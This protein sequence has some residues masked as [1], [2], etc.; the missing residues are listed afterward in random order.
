LLGGAVEGVAARVPTAR[1]LGGVAGLRVVVVA[2]GVIGDE[3][4]P[5][6]VP[7]ADAGVL[8]GEDR[9]LDRVRELAYVAW[10]RVGAESLDGA[11]LEARDR[12]AVLLAEGF[13]EVVGQEVD[14]ALAGAEGWQAEGEDE[15]SVVEIAAEEAAADGV[16]QVDA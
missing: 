11:R 14:V 6:Q 16:V 15:E 3:D 9:C 2:V 13:E 1:G 8:A 4:I 5:R 12:P 7:D 10:P